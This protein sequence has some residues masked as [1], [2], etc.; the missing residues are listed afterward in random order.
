M[1]ISHHHFWEEN[2]RRKHM[3]NYNDGQNLL[4]QVVNVVDVFGQPAVLT[5][6]PFWSTSDATVFNP[7]AAADGLSATGVA[8]KTGTVTITA[9]TT[10]QGSASVTLPVGAGQAVSFQLQV[11]IVPVATALNPIA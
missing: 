11:S 1:V 6:V 8:L 9:T 7:V 10:D 2:K 4:I 3:N 5:V